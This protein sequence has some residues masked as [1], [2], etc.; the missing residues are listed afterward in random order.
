[1]KTYSAPAITTVAVVRETKTSGLQNA[2]ESIVSQPFTL[3][4][5]GFYL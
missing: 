2:P 1:M 3:G 5:V 4:A